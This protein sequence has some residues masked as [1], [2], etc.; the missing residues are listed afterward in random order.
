MCRRE[1]LDGA[2]WAIC[3]G[4]EPRVHRSVPTTKSARNAFRAHSCCTTQQG[5]EWSSWCAALIRSP[6]STRWSASERGSSI[7]RHSE[8]PGGGS[9]PAPP[10]AAGIGEQRATLL[11]DGA[12]VGSA[13]CRAYTA[14]LDRWVSELLGETSGIA[15]VALGSYGRG[16]MCPGSDV[17]LLL[18]HTRPGDIETIADRIWQP[19]RDAQ[20]ELDQSIRTVAEA[21]A[22]AESDLKTELGL[23]D[24]RFVA[25]D[26]QLAKDLMA[27][28]GAQWQRRAPSLLGR[29]EALVRDRHT[30][31]GEVGFLLEPQLKDGRGGLRDIDVL[32]RP[33]RGL[34]APRDPTR[35]AR[36]VGAAARLPRRRSTASPGARP[37]VFVLEWQDQLAEQ[38]GF[39]DADEL[40]SRLA[41]AARTVS[42][43]LDRS[44]RDAHSGATFAAPNGAR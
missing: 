28:A 10:A 5:D 36:R 8:A 17:D 33:R 11:A 23:V 1:P 34:R 14:L 21:L 30:M 40:M 32:R 37:I 9:A 26:E 35:C 13:F 43:T 4:H 22:V 15:L 31:A 27:R 2:R 29:I 44:W 24:A 39:G 3:A 18:L 25:G 38:L 12:L 6:G 20:V 19:I 16:E 41:S 7:T 42:W